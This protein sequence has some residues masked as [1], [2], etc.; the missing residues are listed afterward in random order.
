MLATPLT[1]LDTH[2][3]A[4]ASKELGNVT[5]GLAEQT[6]RCSGLVPLPLVSVIIPVFNDGEAL[7]FCL[8]ALSAQTYPKDCYEIIVVDNNSQEDIR[9]VLKDFG[10][11]V[12]AYESRPGSCA[13]RNRGIKLAHGDVIAFVDADCIPALDW[14]VNGVK[15]LTQTP[16]C[17]LVAGRVEFYFMRK[18]QP[19]VAELYDSMTFLQQERYVAEA[20][21]GV[22]A[23]LLTF[24][25]VVD[26]VGSFD[27]NLQ[28]NGDL[29]WG[30]RVTA[31]GYRAIY[32]ENSCVYHPARPSLSAVY[33]KIRR[34][35][36]SRFY[37]DIGTQLSIAT[38]LAG[39]CK[40]LVRLRPPLRS[41]L[42]K[43]FLESRFKQPRQKVQVFL[44]VIAVH[45]GVV[46]ELVRILLGGEQRR[47]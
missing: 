1:R 26:A 32:A 33:E 45:Y 36:G 17:G 31:Q 16:D 40:I 35:E 42:Y 12:L 23:N 27:P 34:I 43:S 4:V 28:S 5:K 21:W 46:I 11:V 41:A 24:K 6:V 38:F 18:R 14:L 25:H 39:L 7:T 3:L 44:F 2:P 19:T 15:H 13:A 30:C 22:T 20:G 9:G 29:D 37:A 10:D 8:A 47:A